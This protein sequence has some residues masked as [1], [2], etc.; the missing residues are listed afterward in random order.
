MAE[1]CSCCGVRVQEGSGKC[2]FC[3]APLNVAEG[4]Q[5]GQI[6]LIPELYA[7]ED[8]DGLFSLDTLIPITNCWCILRDAKVLRNKKLELLAL[9]AMPV[10]L[11]LMI[12]S[13]LAVV[14]A[15]D[16]GVARRS[17][18]FV[19]GLY[20]LIPWLFYHYVVYRPYRKM[21]RESNITFV[22]KP[23]FSGLTP[24]VFGLDILLYVVFVI[25][26]LSKHFA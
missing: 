13:I 24:A 21:L 18:G 17:Y 14:A 15:A 26:L 8:E 11:L 5:S 2:V 7:T 9:A 3:G 1:R 4:E 23:F 22:R 19:R 12:A 10:I 16:A 25:T 6:P 20:L